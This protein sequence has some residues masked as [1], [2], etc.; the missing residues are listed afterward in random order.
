MSTEMLIPGS[1][2][3]F[4]N[5]RANRGGRDSVRLTLK[6]ELALPLEA[7]ALSPDAIGGLSRDETCSL[8]VLQGKRRYRRARMMMQ[9][10]LT[11]ER[12]WRSASNGRGPWW[13]AG[14]SHM[15]A[16]YPKSWFD[17]LGLVSLLDTVQRLQRAS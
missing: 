6:G 7:E 14:A 3:L 17:A 12:A 5:L 10:G 11:R 13:N 4:Q 1:T 16:A 15:H 2:I 8:P 9:R